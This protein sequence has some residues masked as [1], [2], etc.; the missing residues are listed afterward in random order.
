MPN[1][2]YI[3]SIECTFNNS[4]VSVMDSNLSLL[5]NS[6]SDFKPSINL[7]QDSSDWNNSVV[8]FHLESVRNKLSSLEM[9]KLIDNNPVKYIALSTVD[10][11][12]NLNVDAVHSLLLEMYT[13]KYPILKIDHIQAHIYT[14]MFS[15]HKLSY[16]YILLLASGGTTNL[17]KVDS[18]NHY[19]LLGTHENSPRNRHSHG[20]AAGSVLDRCAVKLG[21]TSADHPDGA[22]EIDRL[23]KGIVIER[24]KYNFD[25]I[26]NI[27]QLNNFDFDFHEIYDVVCM[28]SSKIPSKQITVFAAHL[29]YLIINILLEKVISAA[30][31][32]EINT[33]CFSGGV[34]ANSMLRDLARNYSIKQNIELFFPEKYLVA[35]NA[36]MIGSLAILRDRSNCNFD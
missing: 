1:K 19:E 23:S 9:L 32:Y 29:Q 11:H 10:G 34:A 26:I 30:K 25:D 2:Y 13:E 6:K 14:P 18:I 27:N 31:L 3:I 12:T 36:V 8:Q 33:V 20:R 35:D 24:D 17:Y 16:P 15:N 28:Y 21:L 5:Y 7:K 22:I 4:C